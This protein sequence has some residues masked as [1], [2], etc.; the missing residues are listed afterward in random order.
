MTQIDYCAS[1]VH[2]LSRLQSPRAWTGGKEDARADALALAVGTL[3]DVPL[4][5]IHRPGIRPVDLLVEAAD[6]ATELRVNTLVVDGF[7]DA[8]KDGASSLLDPW[9]GE[10]N[11]ALLYVSRVFHT[12]VILLFPDQAQSTRYRETFGW[13]E[14]LGMCLSHVLD[15]RPLGDGVAGVRVET[16]ADRYRPTSGT[17]LIWQEALGNKKE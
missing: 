1:W 16:L 3:K 6:A 11:E 8:S 5:P 10:F 12:R 13:T 4:F 14:N 17:N 2:G 7:P 15:V 9:A